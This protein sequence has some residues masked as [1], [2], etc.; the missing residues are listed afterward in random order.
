MRVRNSSNSRRGESWDRGSLRRMTI[1]LVEEGKGGLMGMLRLRGDCL[2]MC[3]FGGVY[4]F[5]I[6]V[7]GYD[8]GYGYGYG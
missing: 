2:Y 3:F 8:S 7:H 6:I 1:I 4:G 5:V